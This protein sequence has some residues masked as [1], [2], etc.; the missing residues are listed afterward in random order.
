VQNQR[1]EIAVRVALGANPNRVLREQLS[2]GVWII[3]VGTALGLGLAA[4]LGRAMSSLLFGIKPTD[5]PS[6]LTAAGTVLLIGSLA[7][8]IPAHR[9]TRVDPV[10]ILREE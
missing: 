8:L 1:G 4:A 10:R 9:A 3:L 6:F 7:S 2:G 5:L